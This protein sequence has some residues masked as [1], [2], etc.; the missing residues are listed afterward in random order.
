MG[1]FSKERLKLESVAPDLCRE[2][3]RSIAP[4]E[5]EKLKEWG[6]RPG[7]PKHRLE[8]VILSLFCLRSSIPF[9]LERDKGNTLL[10]YIERL[11]KISYVDALK[12]GTT[13]QFE[14]VLHKR[15]EE[16]DKLDS[17]GATIPR[18]G[19]RFSQN[20]GIDDL[21]IVHWAEM[22]FKRVSL[23]YVDFLKKISE[24]FELVD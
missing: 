7:D 6:V 11:L 3:L 20:I 4:N 19:L 5:L 13:D 15:Y 1:W 14:T 10:L 21:A 2:V 22:N 24:K 12:L 17:P 23:L 18:I 9:A 8:I 16:Y